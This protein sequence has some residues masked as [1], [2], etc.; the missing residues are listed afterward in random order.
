MQNEKLAKPEHYNTGCKEDLDFSS[1]QQM[2]MF[3]LSITPAVLVYQKSG[4]WHVQIALNT[5]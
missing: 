2:S 5:F 1:S 4:I 3:K